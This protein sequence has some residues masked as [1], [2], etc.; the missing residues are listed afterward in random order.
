MSGAALNSEEK[1]EKIVSIVASELLAD[2]CSIYIMRAGIVLEL[3]ATVGLNENLTRMTRFNIGEGIVGDIAA[4]SRPLILADA[5]AHPKFKLIPNLGEETLHS[6]AGVPITRGGSLSGV[7]TIQNKTKRLYKNDEVETLQTIAMI[8]AEMIHAGEIIDRNALVSPNNT[9][10]FFTK[11]SG[12]SL[13]PGLAEG[14]ALLHHPSVKITNLIADDYRRE[15][16]RFDDAVFAMNRSLEK[17]A[18]GA[19]GNDTDYNEI[20]EAYQMFAK[21]RGWLNKI[22]DL[23]TNGLTAEAAVERSQTKLR[24]RINQINDLYLREHLWDFEDLSNRLLKH[25]A[26]DQETPRKTNK[27]IILFARSMGAAELLDYEKA[28]VSGLILEEGMHTAHVAIVA[29]ALGI[30]VVTRV[31]NILAQVQPGDPVLL[32]GDS[33]KIYIRPNISARQAFDA[34][35]L[36]R[37]QN[38]KKA[39]E[40]LDKP[41]VTKDGIKVSLK[42]NAGLLNDVRRIQEV[43]A[44]GVGLFRTEIP[45][46]IEEIFPSVD[47]QTQLYQDIISNTGNHDIIF[48]TLDIGGDKILPYLQRP[49][50]DNPAIGWRAIRIGLDRPVILRQQIRALLRASEKKSLHLLFPMVADERE[51]LDASEIVKLELK[52]ERKNNRSLPNRIYLGLMIEVPSLAFRLP[53]FLPHVD[54]VSVGSNDLFQFF[55]AADRNNPYLAKRYDTLSPAFLSLLKTLCDQAKAARKPIS[56]CGEMASDP[57]GA[58]ALMALGYETLSMNPGSV[59]LIRRLVRSA[60]V[61][62]TA[63]FLMNQLSTNKHSLRENLKAF[64]IDN[65][66]EI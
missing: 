9:D 54:F 35:L 66:I 43:R 22:R 19:S 2:S 52:R 42:I 25:L 16:H 28:N 1:L 30:P 61:A 46:M 14:E 20:L 37:A 21:D 34:Q 31:P 60:D 41:S 27:N 32:D 47:K 57:L 40:A 29:R 58:L 45:F 10:S 44:E 23:I 63:R 8:L 64:S 7:L 49:E 53:E 4:N 55:Y 56:V 13:N 15:L 3:F 5:H 38:E 48:R 50:D 24:Q 6:F 39:K 51:F 65:N 18:Q 12:I 59:G 17:L 11:I 62:K 36:I 33:G 26:G